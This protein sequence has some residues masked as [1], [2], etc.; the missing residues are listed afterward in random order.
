MVVKLGHVFLLGYHKVIVLRFDGTIVHEWA[1]TNDSLSHS[2]PQI[3]SP[4]RG[5]PMLFDTENRLWDSHGGVLAVWQ[6]EEGP[7]RQLNLALVQSIEA[8]SVPTHFIES[9]F[10]EQIVWVARADHTIL[11]YDSKTCQAIGSVELL[12]D[13]EECVV[14]SLC[15]GEGSRGILVV[16]SHIREPDTGEW[17]SRLGW[18]QQ[19]SSLGVE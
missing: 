9:R 7:S 10:T 3:I 15:I 14:D 16:G 5:L 2:A 19:C 6:V 18:Y 13:I 17:K 4:T 11:L 1:L 12:N 8:T